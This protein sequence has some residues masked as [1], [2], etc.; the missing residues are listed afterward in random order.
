MSTKRVSVSIFC[1]NL[2]VKSISDFPVWLPYIVV[3][4]KDN[5]KKK[6]IRFQWVVH[7]SLYRD[8]RS[9]GGVEWRWKKKN[10]ENNF[11]VQPFNSRVCTSP[12]VCEWEDSKKMSLKLF[13]WKSSLCN[14]TRHVA[15]VCAIRSHSLI[16]QT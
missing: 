10:H 6:T 16:P 5:W 14:W 2:K 11:Q 8:A 7:S 1:F 3:A 9:F 15:Q 12:E 4:S 13:F